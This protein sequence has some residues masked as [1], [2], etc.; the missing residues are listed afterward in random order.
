MKEILIA[1]DYSGNTQ[2]IAEM[3]F[4][5]A[6]S[7]NGHITLLHVIADPAFLL[8]NRVFARNGIFWI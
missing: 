5:I 8:F 6:K 4:S 1:L 7:L 2:K 3:G